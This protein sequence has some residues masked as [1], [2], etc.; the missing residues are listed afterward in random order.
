ME[1]A[2]G[3]AR[4][5]A[6]VD[7]WRREGHT[8]GFV[9]TM[10]ALHEGH[11]SLVRRAKQ[12]N[13][14]CIASVF[15]NPTQFAPTE[16]LSRY[17]R[18]LEGDRKKLESVA[19][20][21]LFT[22]TPE[23]FYPEGFVTWVTVEKLT[24]G[25][26]GASRPTHFRGV[27]TVCAKLFNVIR[28]DRIYMGEK[29]YQQVT[30][31]RAMVRDLEMSWEIVPCPTFREKDGLAMSSRNVFLSPDERKR[32]V[33]L[34]RGLRLASEAYAKGERMAKR[35]EALV[36]AEVLGV[37]ARLDYATVVD[38]DDLAPLH[39]A[40]DRSVLVLAA[41]VGKTRLIDNHRL[42]RKFPVA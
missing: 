28:P 10:G 40:D 24:A 4:A 18:D 42:S 35:L 6:L 26:E 17:P 29:D 33:A 20:D 16:D 2:E 32:A 15:V 41:F 3:K 37:D 34:S 7:R 23:E 38:G 25:L 36:A 21:G 9:P 14:R 30:V 19:C 1:H 13:A 22:T 8:I 31:L 5:R 39:L 12:E 27:T 11:L